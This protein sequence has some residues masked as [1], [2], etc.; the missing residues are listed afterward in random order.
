MLVGLQRWRRPNKFEGLSRCS[1][2]YH[3]IIQAFPH[4]IWFGLLER[5]AMENSVHPFSERGDWWFLLPV[6]LSEPHAR[7]IRR[8]GGP[9]R[10]Q[11]TGRVFWLQG[12]IQ[13]HSSMSDGPDFRLAVCASKVWIRVEGVG[14]VLDWCE[15]G[16]VRGQSLFSVQWVWIVCEVPMWEICVWVYFTV[17]RWKLRLRFTVRSI[18]L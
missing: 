15:F 12:G 13:G 10:W 9:G 4:L 7:R 18:R 16:A 5:G 14:L 2:V 6:C 17:L 1:A 11:H 3:G 8:R